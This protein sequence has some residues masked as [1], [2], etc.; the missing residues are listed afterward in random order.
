MRIFVPF[1][2]LR[3]ETYSVCHALGAEFIPL[4][5]HEKDYGRYWD[6][7]WIEGESFINVEQDV[8]PTKVLLREMWDCPHD[9]CIAQY[10]YPWTGSPVDHSPIGCAK[11]SSGFIG[12]NRQI[13]FNGVVW[14]EPQY[15]I[16]NASLNKFHQHY[17]NA[18][19]LHVT[20][21][22]PLDMRNKYDRPEGK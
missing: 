18:M 22:W 1:T 4:L 8:V 20:A 2:H 17:P 21:D 13:V 5:D 9:Y 11:F 14:H 10:S 15:Q 16:I 19:H 7:R 6:Q 3:A 12:A